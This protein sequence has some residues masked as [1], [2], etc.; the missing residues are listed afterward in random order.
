[1][2]NIYIKMSAIGSTLDAVGWTFTQYSY[3]EC[4]F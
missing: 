4:H 1:L 2:P 3:V